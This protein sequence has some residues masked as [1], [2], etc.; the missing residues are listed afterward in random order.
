MNIKLLGEDEERA[1]QINEL[2]SFEDKLLSDSSLHTASLLPL[3]H[4][5]QLGLVLG[6]EEPQTDLD[7]FRD[8]KGE[9]PE[10]TEKESQAL[11]ALDLCSDFKLSVCTLIALQNKEKRIR[12]IKEN[13]VSN[14]DEYKYYRIK[15]GILCREYS[16]DKNTTQYLG[17]YIPTSIIFSVVIYVHKHFLHPSKTHTLK[18]FSALYYY[19]FA[20]RAVNKICEAC[21]TCA[22]TRNAEVKNNTVGRERT[23]KPGKPREGVSIDILYFPNSSRVHKYGLI[24][25]DLYSLYI[26]FYPLKSKNSTEIAKI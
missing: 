12:E 19:P 3:V 15:S 10:L 20:R 25:A 8:E 7:N 23:L 16:I 14:P 6:K 2:L 11:L 17:I 21:I 22:Q 26:S 4:N 5:N 18:E 13:L 24:V 1:M 9:L